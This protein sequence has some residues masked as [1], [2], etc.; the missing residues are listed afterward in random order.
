MEIR[1]EERPPT[2]PGKAKQGGD[3][4]SGRDYGWVERAVWT[5]RM[6]AALEQGVKGGSWFSLMDKV[7]ATGNLRAAARKVIANQGSAGVD[8]IPVEVFEEHLDANVDRLH[9]ELRQGRY[10]PQPIRRT[11]IPKAGSKEMRPLGIPTVRDR[12]VQT[13]LCNVLEP[14]FE[15]EF[16]ECSYG[17]RPGR[18][19]KDA[20]R[21]VVRWLDE[22]SLWVVD[23]D[24]KS[25][26]DTI[27]HD[28]LMALLCQRVADGKVLGLVAA[29]LRQRVVEEGREWSAEAGSP[30][31]S[32][33][34]PL[35]ANVY[36]NPLDH[37][38]TEG[39]FRMVRYADDRAPRRR[40][41]EATMAS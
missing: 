38:M 26:F 30:Q 10:V 41:E 33:L 12:V 11:Y 15:R 39:G 16:A 22:D 37:L 23:V 28:R 14:I 9:D 8:R 17:F 29:Y 19:C 25:Y 40:G 31:G 7:Y 4:P 32:A 3:R 13:A 35:L 6:L 20:L 24:L 18:G 27:P 21:E 34:S 36:L 1:R 2:V 5:D